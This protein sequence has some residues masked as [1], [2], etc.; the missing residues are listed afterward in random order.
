MKLLTG[1]FLTFLVAA[2][3][4]SDGSKTLMIGNSGEPATLDPHKYNLRLEETLL[5]DLFLGLTTFSADGE[6]VAGA[7]ESWETS[8]DGLTWRFFFEGRPE[9]VGWQKF[10]SGGFCLFI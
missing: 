4:S 9:M 3:V 10:N 5:N 2:T 6:I 8:A 7:A 1:L